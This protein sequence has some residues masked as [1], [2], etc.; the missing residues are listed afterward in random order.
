[1]RDS[2]LSVYFMFSLSG[3]SP[4]VV[5][6]SIR[7]GVVQLDPWLEPYKEA[8]RTRFSYAQKWIKAIEESEGGLEKFSKV[9][10]SPI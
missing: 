6:C 5:L 7:P 9:W 1:M 10:D 2:A 8:L 4:S 3:F